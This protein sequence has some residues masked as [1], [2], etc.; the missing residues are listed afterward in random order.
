MDQVEEVLTFIYVWIV[1]NVGNGTNEGK[2]QNKKL[3]PYTLYL[4]NRVIWFKMAT[5]KYSRSF[6]IMH[7]SG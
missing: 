5:N 3:V 4:A 2:K 1:R 6:F 7:S